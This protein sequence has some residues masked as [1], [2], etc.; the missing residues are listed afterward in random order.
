VEVTGGC[1]VKYGVST[2]PDLRLPLRHLSS[3]TADLPR[4][5]GLVRERQPLATLQAGIDEEYERRVKTLAV[6]LMR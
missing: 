1:L 3:Q 6:E 5:V 4:T 2:R